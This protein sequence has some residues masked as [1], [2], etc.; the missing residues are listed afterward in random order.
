MRNSI[1]AILGLILPTTARAAASIDFTAI[2]DCPMGSSVLGGCGTTDAGAYVSDIVTGNNGL[3]NIFI[4]LMAAMLVFYSVKLL[5]GSR[6]ENTLTEVKMAYINALLGAVLVGGAFAF[7]NTFATGNSTTLVV[8][9]AFNSRLIIVGLFFEGLVSAVTIA[10]VS[11]QGMR[12]V[13]A[14]DEGAI[15][16]ARKRFFH[17]MVGTAICLLVIPIVDTFTGG[18]TAL[19]G[20][21]G[22]IAPAMVEVLGIA[23]FALTIFGALAVVGLIVAGVML[24]ISVDESL[25]DR[26]KKLVTG[27]IVALGVVIASYSIISLFV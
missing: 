3:I 24:V 4:G 21:S 11:I 9:S 16:S 2:D 8:Q 5:L 6:D 25:K 27:C 1:P 7:S 18:T 12:L 20:S 13:I 23:K 26:A 10:N 17:G 15:D 19:G 14:Q 22:T